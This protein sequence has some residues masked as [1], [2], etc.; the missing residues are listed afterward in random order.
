[1]IH[2]KERR[3]PFFSERCRVQCQIILLITNSENNVNNLNEMWG[4]PWTVLILVQVVVYGKHDLLNV[5]ITL[6]AE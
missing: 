3:Q 6:L 5:Q 1:V 2:S 4:L